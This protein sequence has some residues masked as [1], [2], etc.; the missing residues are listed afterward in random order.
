MKTI[1]P[2]RKT[3]MGNS[4]NPTHLP[5]FCSITKNDRNH[6]INC[7]GLLSLFKLDLE[8]RNCSRLLISFSI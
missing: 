3:N 1:I 5:K 8:K 4:H 2:C 6:L 7:N